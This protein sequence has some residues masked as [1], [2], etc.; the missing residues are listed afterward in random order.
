MI[1]NFRNAFLRRLLRLMFGKELPIPESRARSIM[2]AKLVGKVPFHV[3]VEALQI[4]DIYSEWIAQPDADEQRVILFFHGGGY[5]S[6]SVA[7]HKLL[8]VSL[9]RATGMRILLPEYRLAPENPFPAALEDALSAYRWLLARGF[10]PAD[11]I[12][13][14]DS[15][16]GGL[17]LATTLALR[18]AGKPLPAAVVC[19]SP[20]ADLTLSGES[21]QIKAKADPILTARKLRH[22]ASSYTDEENMSNPLVSPVYADFH[23]FPPLLIQVGS[24][25]I[26][27]DDATQVAERAKTAGVDVT[28]KIWPSMWHVWHAT[29]TW[30]PESR[31]A[32]AE[33]GQFVREHFNGISPTQ[34]MSPSEERQKQESRI[35]K[36]ES[37][38]RR[39]ESNIVPERVISIHYIE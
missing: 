9:A 7:I 23:D 24:E 25:E 37:F 30:L 19:L 38:E 29:G 39:T 12:I 32:L 1:R 21:Y 28:L 20:W 6:G 13:A 36:R 18:D 5:V 31:E 34:S 35:G 4:G 14:G 11:I 22:W 16:G 8:C 10:K 33:I 26:M 15:A 3:R 17:A 27:L 2:L